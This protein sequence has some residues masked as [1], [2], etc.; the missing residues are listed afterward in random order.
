MA[1]KRLKSMIP[2][3]SRDDE[4]RKAIFANVAKYEEKGIA[5][6]VDEELENRQAHEENRPLW[7]L[8]HMCVDEPT[9]IRICHDAK[10]STRGIGLNDLLIGRPNLTNNLVAVLIL[11]RQHKYVFSTDITGFF[12]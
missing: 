3:L 9:K 5:V 6:T 4:R 1:M 7:H 2:R 8:P 11:I 10:A 12:H